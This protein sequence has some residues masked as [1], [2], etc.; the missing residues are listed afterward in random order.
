MDF[1][2]LDDVSITSVVER[3]KNPP[4][5]LSGGGEARPNAVSVTLPD[6]THKSFGKIT[7]FLIPKGGVL[8]LRTAGGG[9]YGPPSERDREAI[10]RDLREGYITPDFAKRHYGYVEEEE[11]R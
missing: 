9:G 7:R 2:V 3:T 10:A 6:G 11:T 8:A 5:G 1:E 4:W